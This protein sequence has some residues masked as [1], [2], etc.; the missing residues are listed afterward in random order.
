[1]TLLLSVNF[2]KVRSIAEKIIYTK[3]KTGEQAALRT[4]ACEDAG[5]QDVSSVAGGNAKEDSHVG[6]QMGGFLQNYKTR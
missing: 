5:Q 4:N 1:M 6:R 3:N 2:Q